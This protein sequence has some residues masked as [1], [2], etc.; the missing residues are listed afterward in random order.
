MN[1]SF[2]K[3]WLA[4]HIKEKNTLIFTATYTCFAAIVVA[5]S[6]IKS[7]QKTENILSCDSNEFL[8]VIM[9]WHKDQ[10]ID[11]LSAKQS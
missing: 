9:T 10:K 4:S 11:G 6:P 3:R 8:G 5:I 2:L 7:D 1:E